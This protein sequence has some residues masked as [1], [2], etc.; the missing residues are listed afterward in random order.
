MR[1]GGDS[2]WGGGAG[3]WDTE[4]RGWALKL[5][6]WKVMASKVWETSNRGEAFRAFAWLEATEDARERLSSPLSSLP[7]ALLEG[8]LWS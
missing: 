1:R 3:E 6:E 4:G 2:G 5:G 8:E 7:L